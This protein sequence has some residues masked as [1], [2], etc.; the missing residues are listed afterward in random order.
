MRGPRAV[1]SRVGFEL[2]RTEPDAVE[3]TEARRESAYALKRRPKATPSAQTSS[4][5]TKK[6]KDAAPG[7]AADEGEAEA[8]SRA[9]A[10]LKARRALPRMA[11]TP[12]RP[13]VRFGLQPLSGPA[14]HATLRTPRWPPMLRIAF[15]RAR[16]QSDGGREASTAGCLDALAV[17]N[18]PRQEAAQQR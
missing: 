8:G 13:F 16:R 5:L 3:G 7:E 15:D 6:V 2:P 11:E 9:S 12:A 17:D 10:Q 1:R 14:S 18:P 4:A